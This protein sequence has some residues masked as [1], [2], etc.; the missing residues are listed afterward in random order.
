MANKKRLIDANALRKK[1]LEDIYGGEMFIYLEDLDEA[2]TVDAVEVV[3]A[4][5]V[6]IYSNVEYEDTLIRMDRQCPLCG[7]LIHRSDNYCP[8]CGA[9]MDGGV[10]DE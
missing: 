7:A 3:H 4:K 5:A 9:R 6:P 8:V 10:E 2:P 1:A